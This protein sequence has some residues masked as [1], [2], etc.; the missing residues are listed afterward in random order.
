MKQ[1]FTLGIAALLL[2]SV[3]GSP[4]AY[5]QTTTTTTTNTDT[6]IEFISTLQ[7]GQRGDLV[8]ILQATLAKD[9]T[10]LDP[11]Y[12]TG[13]F[14]PLTR[15]AVKKFQ[16]KNN[17]SQVG[18][19]GPQTRALL[20]AELRTQ[21]LAVDA[22]DPTC[23][24]IPPGHLIAPGFIKKNGGVAPQTPTCMKLPAGIAKKISGSWNGGVDT[25]APVVSTPTVTA[26][27]TTGGT[28]GFTTNEDAVFELSYGTSTSYGT[29]VPKT[30][31][32]AKTHSYAFTN[33]TVNTTYYYQVKAYDQKGNVTTATGSFTTLAIADTTA[34]VISNITVGTPTASGVTITWATDDASSSKVYVSTTPVNTASVVPVV[35]SGTRTAHSVTI[36]GLAANTQHYFIVES[37]N[38]ANLGSQ[39]AQGTFTTAASDTTA[40]AVSAIVVTPAATSATIAWVTNENASSKIYLSPTASVVKA[41][42]T[43]ISGAGN[44]TAHSVVVTGLTANTTYYY[45]I[46]SID[47][48]NNMTT[49]A[50]ATFA[51]TI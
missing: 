4:A 44:T 32:Y 2:G 26:L 21:P 14:G 42:A 39:G 23:V 8:K 6:V 40:P 27:T 35:V 34:P 46:E 1:P 10:I 48:S 37:V 45:L 49:T 33:L 47:A 36:T 29:T 13:Y 5:A 11:K 9:P 50:E 43:Q 31:T 28:L 24:K 12:I 38:A 19:V 20:N 3:L 7:V 16:K 17:L 22:Q 30:T 15:D 18:V 51:T 41:S 25:T